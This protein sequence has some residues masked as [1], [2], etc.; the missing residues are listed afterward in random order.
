MACEL[1]ADRFVGQVAGGDHMRNRTAMLANSF[2]DSWRGALRE[3][4]D[5]ARESVE[6]MQRLAN[7]RPFGPATADSGR[8]GD[9]AN[10]AVS[11]RLGTQIDKL[12]ID[13]VANIKDV[14]GID[15]GDRRVGGKTVLRQA[16]AAAAQVIADR[17]M[18]SPIK[19]AFREHF[20]KDASLS[21]LSE[22]TRQNAVEQQSRCVATVFAAPGANPLQF[23][24]TVS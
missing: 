24:P 11:N 14:R 21:A 10:L 7:P 6:R 13:S 15:V 4:S 3:S 8:Q 9:H 18:L 2:C 5:A 20:R 22:A 16:D 23:E 19:S 12:A 17:L 1:F